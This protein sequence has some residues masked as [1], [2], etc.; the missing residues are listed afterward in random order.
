MLKLMQRLGLRER[1][2]ETEVIEA[3][4]KS[5][6]TSSP[7]IR[8]QSLCAKESSTSAFSNPRCTTSLNKSPSPKSSEN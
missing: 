3:C 6:A 1:L 8:R 7:R 5:S 2:R 4:Q